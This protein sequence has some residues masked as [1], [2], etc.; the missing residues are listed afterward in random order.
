MKVYLNIPIPN[1]LQKKMTAKLLDGKTV[2]ESL[3]LNIKQTI[4]K[5]LAQSPLPPKLAVILVGHDPASSIYVANKRKACQD[6]GILSLS[7]NLPEETSELDL[8]ALITKLNQ[9]ETIHGILVQLPLPQHINA[10]HIIEAIRPDKDVDGFHPYNQGRLMQ[11]LPLLRPCTPFGVMQLL[12]AYDIPVKSRD[13]VVVGVSNIVGRPMALEF[14]LAGATITCCH[15]LTQNLKK[16]I[17]QAEIVVVA[18]GVL[19]VVPADFFCKEQVVIDVGIH[20]MPD[21]RLRGDVDFDAVQK[22]V[23]WITPVPGGVGPMTVVSLLQNTLLA[24][25]LSTSLSIDFLR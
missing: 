12:K 18:T 20:R 21:G 9:D 13:V 25:K 11:R 17:Q 16:H 3:R 14:L 2:S 22:R 15:R 8:L 4:A 5:N 6:V 10:I 7:Y 1:Q 23:G 19:D 24:Q